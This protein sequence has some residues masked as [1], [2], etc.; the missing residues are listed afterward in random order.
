MGLFFTV[1]QPCHSLEGQSDEAG[2]SSHG[3]QNIAYGAECPRPRTFWST[4]R[5]P[6]SRNHLW[7]GG[8]EFDDAP[9][10]AAEVIPTGFW[11]SATSGKVMAAMGDPEG[12]CQAV[13]RAVGA[14]KLIQAKAVTDCPADLVGDRVC[15]GSYGAR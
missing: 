5:R 11:A 6:F 13:E 2:G 3:H 7:P 14:W 1:R 9:N 8:F 4:R 12:C 15:G 10:G